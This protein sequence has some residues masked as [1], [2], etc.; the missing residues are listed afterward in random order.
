MLRRQTRKQSSVLKPILG[1]GLASFGLI[2]ADI[3]PA[4]DIGL[5]AKMGVQAVL[6][7][8]ALIEGIALVW[9]VRKLVARNDAVDKLVTEAV[10]TMQSV[11]DAIEKCHKG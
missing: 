5:I 10:A 9:S 6:G 2:V 11:K 7:T 8:V 4:E 1:I 3:L